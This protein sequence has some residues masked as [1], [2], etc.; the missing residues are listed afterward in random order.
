MRRLSGRE[1]PAD[2]RSPAVADR[3]HRDGLGSSVDASLRPHAAG[4][5][6]ERG[7]SRPVGFHHIHNGVHRPPDDRDGRRDDPGH[8]AS[9]LGGLLNNPKWRLSGCHPLP[10]AD[11]LEMS[12]GCSF[13]VR[14]AAGGD[15]PPETHSQRLFNRLLGVRPHKANTIGDRI[16]RSLQSAGHI[17]RKNSSRASATSR[18]G[19]GMNRVEPRITPWR[20]RRSRRTS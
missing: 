16:H 4:L 3:T 20:W 18:F 14:P 5:V 13:A 11:H 15:D 10:S 2:L 9:R 1:Q 19:A 7:S 8:G 17:V 6:S 12:T